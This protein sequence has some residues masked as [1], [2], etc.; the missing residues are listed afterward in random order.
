[1]SDLKK[2]INEFRKELTSLLRSI[3]TSYNSPMVKKTILGIKMADLRST[4]RR[5]GHEV[6]LEKKRLDKKIK[7]LHE[8]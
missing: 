5:L 7:K 8:S 6:N 4:M 3:D 2:E 1:M